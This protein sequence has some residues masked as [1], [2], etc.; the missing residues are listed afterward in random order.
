MNC[1]PCGNQGGR[2]AGGV[3]FDTEMVDGQI[4]RYRG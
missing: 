1:Y 2:A 4:D 3:E